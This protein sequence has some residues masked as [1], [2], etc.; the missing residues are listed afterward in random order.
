MSI[1]V[2][3]DF[4]CPECYLAARRTDVLVAAQ[5]P[6]DFRAVEHRPDLPVDGLRLTPEAKEVLHGRFESVRAT[7][8]AGERLPWSMP[9]RVVKSEASVS[10]YAEAYASPAESD[11]RRIL[12]DLYWRED[13]DIG[14]P[15]VLRTPLTGPFL[16]SDS[17]VDS[18]RQA[19][20]AVSVDRGPISTS[21]YRRIRNWRGE[22]HDLGAPDLPV[23]LVGG[24]TLHGI[25]ALRRLG[26]EIGYVG[27][28]VDPD[29]PD[30]R[31]YPHVDVRPSPTWVSQIGGRWRNDYRPGGIAGLPT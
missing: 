25:E 15:K 12:F 2:Y 8:L 6:V 5:V 14:D 24:A 29:L 10:A 4:S 1:V 9:T 28:D 23:V 16:R 18:L 7:L 31:R 17:S 3:A 13:A 11:V 19:G 22:W 30:P 26:K 21:A 20:L 27:A